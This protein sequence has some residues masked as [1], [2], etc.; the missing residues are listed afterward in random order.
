MPHPRNHLR[1]EQ[2]RAEI[3]ALSQ[4][5]GPDHIKVKVMKTGLSK[6]LDERRLSLFPEKPLS[7]Q[8]LNS[9]SDAER[10]RVNE[11]R[12]GAVAFEAEP[13]VA[14]FAASLRK[15]LDK[16]IGLNELRSKKI[17]SDT[18]FVDGKAA[19]I[20]PGKNK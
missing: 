17:I 13:E 7:S 10:A 8:S 11:I 6:L 19:L 5:L 4:T 15:A 12:H 3:R 20:R 14:I 9:I 16:L 18:D 2:L 1:I